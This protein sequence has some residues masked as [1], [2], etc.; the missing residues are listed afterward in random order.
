MNKDVSRISRARL[1][2]FFVGLHTKAT[3]KKRWVEIGHFIQG[4]DLFLRRVTEQNG[5][6]GE[7]SDGL[8]YLPEGSSEPAQNDTGA[9]AA[10][11]QYMNG[12]RPVAM[13]I[14]DKLLLFDFEKRLDET[15]NDN[16]LT[17]STSTRYNDFLKSETKFT[18]WVPN[19]EMYKVSDLKLNSGQ[20]T[21]KNLTPAADLGSVTTAI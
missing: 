7:E 10:Y 18:G 6:Q 8:G 13:L 9:F 16:R 21:H 19:F 2:R 3:E 1:D 17:M 4:F 14:G 15:F 11:K 12:K 5:L 20:L